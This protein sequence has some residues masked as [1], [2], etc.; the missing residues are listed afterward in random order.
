MA[1]SLQTS[2]GWTG[3]KR[4]QAAVVSV[5]MLAAFVWVFRAGGLPLLPPART[6]EGVNLLLVA[7]FVLGMTVNMVS[8]FARHHF[9]IAPIASV[10]FRR[11]LTINAIGTALIT[12]L[13]L[14]LGE[15]A[16]PAMLRTKGH[17]SAWAV[18]GTVG[19]ERI[20]DGLT[21]SGTLITGLLLATPRDP[22]PDRIGDFPV[23]ASL[24]PQVAWI[25][26]VGFGLAFVVMA[27]FYRYREQAR[28]LTERVLGLVWKAAAVRVAEVVIR[29]SEGFRFLVD[30]RSTVPYLAITILSVLAQVWG[31]ELLA[32][33]VGMHELSFAE[34]M[35]VTGVVAL[36]FAMPNAPGFFGTVQ[37]ALYGGLASYIPPDKIA[38]Q[39]AA[40]VFIFYVT[41]L[42]LVVLFAMLA[43]F[44]EWATPNVQTPAGS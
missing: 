13:P 38:S 11:I 44:A 28:R 41:Y 6:L 39:G 18:T 20:L 35:V 19:A 3:G 23:S 10:P 31:T 4:G 22:L 2:S 40:L 26:S 12:F 25:A 17:L 43:L 1:E 32:A 21:F 29:L 24:V 30:A 27:F 16:R 34:A 42:G 37:L 15:L 8:R 33:A 14:R 5:L 7:G 9:L 36:G